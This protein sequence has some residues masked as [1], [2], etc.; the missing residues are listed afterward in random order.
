MPLPKPIRVLSPD[1]VRICRDGDA[2]ILEPADAAVGTTRFVLGAERVA[3][4]TDAEI[5]AAWNESVTAQQDYADALDL[6]T[7]EIPLGRPQLDFHPRARQW[8]PRGHVVRMEILGT[9]DAGPDEPCVCVDG[10]DLTVS[11]FLG[12]LNTFAGWGARLTFVDAHATHV[13][14]EVEV[15]E[16]MEPER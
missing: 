1:E 10:R 5:L 9:S 15:R 6:P 16:P 12:M 3:R 8:V 13:A 2:A 7:I 11:E 14:P 4:M